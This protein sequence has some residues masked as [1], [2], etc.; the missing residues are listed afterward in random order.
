[1][2]KFLGLLLTIALLI[3][4]CTTTN[5]ADEKISIR[6]NITSIYIDKDNPYIRV[7]DNID[8][9]TEYDKAIVNITKDTVIKNKNSDKVY[10]IT[11]FELG[12]TVEVIFNGPVSESN[13]V[14]ATAKTISIINE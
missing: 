2:K 11:D 5:S 7:E 3:V 1:M 12:M 13:P 6:G 9:D 8:K 4:G 10:N 14:K